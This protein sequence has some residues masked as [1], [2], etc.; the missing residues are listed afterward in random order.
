M[1][2]CIKATVCSVSILT[3]RLLLLICGLCYTYQMK[4]CL[5]V[6]SLVHEYCIP[7]VSYP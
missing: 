1:H 3:A 6:I 4:L 7:M 2:S 5:D